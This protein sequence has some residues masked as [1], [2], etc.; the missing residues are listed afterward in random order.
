MLG[1]CSVAGQ[2]V[3][4]AIRDMHLALSQESR[5]LD[6]PP[7]YGRYICTIR[8]ICT[9][10]IYIDTARAHVLQAL[11]WCGVS[12]TYHLSLRSYLL[13][14]FSLLLRKAESL[15]FSLVAPLLFFLGMVNICSSKYRSPACQF[16]TFDPTAPLQK[17]AMA[18]PGEPSSNTS[19]RFLKSLRENPG[20]TLLVR[21]MQCKA[22]W[23]W[24]K[25]AA[26]VSFVSITSFPYPSLPP[27]CAL[28]LPP[29]LLPSCRWWKGR[30]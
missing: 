18:D 12:Y 13:F 27:S 19:Y 9:I 14:P 16:M 23:P 1:P 8:V 3:L 30:Q 26:S 28:S 15:S 17:C 7:P 5:L 10:H 20:K 11:A 6:P 24:K 21:H 22:L 29:S 2:D 25:S 4:R